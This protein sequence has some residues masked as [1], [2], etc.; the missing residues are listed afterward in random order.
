MY[1]LAFR[2]SAPKSLAQKIH[3]RYIAYNERRGEPHIRHTYRNAYIHIT[4][5]THTHPPPLLQGETC[6]STTFMFYGLDFPTRKSPGVH[7]YHVRLAAR[8]TCPT[9]RGLRSVVLW[10][11]TMTMMMAA[12]RWAYPLE[13]CHLFVSFPGPRSQT[14]L[15]A[16]L[17]GRYK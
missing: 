10:T 11:I 1:P 17:F 4:T 14:T 5:H 3:P 12:R 2:S 16:C 7:V 15:G 6:P 9:R 8:P 13:K